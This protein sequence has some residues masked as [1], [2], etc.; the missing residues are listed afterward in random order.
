M[1]YT[2]QELQAVQAQQKRRWMAVGI[3]SVLMLIALIVVLVIR[4]NGGMADT[5]AQIT[6]DALTILIGVTLIAGWGLFIKPLHCYQRHIENLLHGRT[7]VCE[8][9]TFCHLDEDESTVDGVSYYALTLN[10][11]DEKQKPYERL[12]Y[13]DVQKPRPDFKEGD[14][15]RIVYHDRFIGQVELRA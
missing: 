8:D 1:M 15:L 4:G 13:Y 2:E 7:H 6:V 14:P 3:P 5:P 12:F 10:C 9:G 11:L